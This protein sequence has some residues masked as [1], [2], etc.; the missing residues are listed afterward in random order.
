MNLKN[1][2]AVFHEGE[3][4]SCAEYA[5]IDYEIPIMAVYAL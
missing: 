5:E 2:D 1:S 4:R 3:A